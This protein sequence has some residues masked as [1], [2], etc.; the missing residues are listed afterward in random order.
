MINVQW[1]ENGKIQYENFL[2]ESSV[3]DFVADLKKRECVDIKITKDIEKVIA[4]R[5]R[6]Y[7]S[8]NRKHEVII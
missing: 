6:R 4:E 2:Y 3:N 7:N 5:I 8:G 1:E